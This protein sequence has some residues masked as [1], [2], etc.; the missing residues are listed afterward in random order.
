MRSPVRIPGA[1][2][3]NP[4]TGIMLL[5]SGLAARLA[6]QIGLC[7]LLA[8]SPGLLADA[9]ESKSATR[10]APTRP[11]PNRT[12]PIRAVTVRGR[13]VLDHKGR[14]TPP[15][16]FTRGLQTSGLVYSGGKLW[17]LGD[18][19]SQYP[20]HLFAID[21]RTARLISSPLRPDFDADLSARNPEFDVYRGIPNSDFEGIC[22][23]PSEA[24]TLF[25]VTEDKVPWV[26]EV[27]LDGPGRA[28][29]MQFSRLKFPD[30]LVPW[31]RDPNYRFEGATVSGDGKTMYL[32]FERAADELPRIVSLS[33]K[34]VRSGK[35]IVPRVLPFP[36]D[37]VPRRADKP[38]ARLNINGLGLFRSK[39]RD[40][41][42]AVARDQE[43]ILFLDVD[44]LRIDG[45]VDLILRDPDGNP[46]H[47]VSPEGLAID[48]DSGRLWMINDPDSVRGNY[49]SLAHERARGRFA[50]YAPLLFEMKLSELRE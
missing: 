34:E 22:R 15:G 5:T 30:G 23:H 41:L 24:K 49:R 33:L 11:S 25:A 4:L 2:E 32:A 6:A 43:R 47:W 18:Q 20:G 50:E 45:A 29:F 31:R 9:D 39:G 14:P 12:I 7:I 1:P 27:R 3:N 21:P 42:A 36:F 13:W 44:Q 16:S 40:F 38:L 8:L 17:S 26:V 28:T 48:P 10:P 19:R 37:A 35:P 46:M